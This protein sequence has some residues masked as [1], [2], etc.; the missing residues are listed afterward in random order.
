MKASDLLVFASSGI[1]LF[2][3]LLTASLA[4]EGIVALIRS[5]VNRWRTDKD[6]SNDVMA[7]TLDA[8]ANRLDKTEI[9]RK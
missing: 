1:P 5:F 9:P 4:K 3:I 7:D 6:P 8:I 2:I